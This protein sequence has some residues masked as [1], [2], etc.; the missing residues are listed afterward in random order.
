MKISV[1]RFLGIHLP[2]PAAIIIYL[3]LQIKCPVKYFFHIDCPTCG[4]TRAMFALFR[5]DFA[6]YIHFNPMALPFLL[7]LLFGLPGRLFPIKSK[8]K[9]LI[10]IIGAS[11]VLFV[12]ILRLFFV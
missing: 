8:V 1:K 2:V 3:A 7:I 6:A 11:C 9:N 12:Y 10:I 5:G 4:M